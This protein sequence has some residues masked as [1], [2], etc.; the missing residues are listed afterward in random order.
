MDQGVRAQLKAEL[1]AGER[2]DRDAKRLMSAGDVEGGLRAARL[3]RESDARAAALLTETS[4]GQVREA[5]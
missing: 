1:A 2:H 4:E 3:A 5:S